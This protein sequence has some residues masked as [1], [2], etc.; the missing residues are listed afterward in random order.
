MRKPISIAKELIRSKGVSFTSNFPRANFDQ[1]EILAGY[2][3]RGAARCLIHQHDL[4][5]ERAHHLRSLG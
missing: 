3:T 4:S 2:L 5:P 1:L